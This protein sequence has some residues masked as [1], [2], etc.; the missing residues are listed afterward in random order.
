MSDRY[1]PG[2]TIPNCS[3]GLNKL[4]L[5]APMLKSIDSKKMVIHQ[6]CKMVAN[7]VNVISTP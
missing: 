7:G 1:I 5:L 6:E 4:I 3:G 2:S